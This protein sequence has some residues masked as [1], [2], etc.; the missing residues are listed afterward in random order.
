M[1]FAAISLILLMEHIIA[2]GWS[3]SRIGQALSPPLDTA[4][5]VRR[6]AYYLDYA[7][8][9]TPNPPVV[10]LRKSTNQKG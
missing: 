3:F 2:A 9:Y 4:T 6:G 10:V 1:G 5:N 7:P 8:A